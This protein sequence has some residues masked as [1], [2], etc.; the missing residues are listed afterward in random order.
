VFYL[1]SSKDSNFLLKSGKNYRYFT[2]RPTCVSVRRSDWVGNLQA[3]FVNMVTMVASV[4]GQRS[5][6]GDSAKIVR[7]CVHFL[8]CQTYIY[9]FTD[10][11]RTGIHQSIQWFAMSWTTGVRFPVGTGKTRYSWVRFEVLMTASIKM[12]VFWVLAPCSLAQVYR[13]FGDAC[14][15]HHQGDECS[16]HLWN[17]Y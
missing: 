5:N 9:L 16:K 11:R 17:F 6:S 2:W 8:N 13:R 12:A 3:T 14:C 1:N 10:Q 15:Q 7:P 4:K